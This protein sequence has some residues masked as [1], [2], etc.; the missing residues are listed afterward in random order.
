MTLLRSLNPLE[1][2]RSHWIVPF[3]SPLPFFWWLSAWEREL[4]WWV[5][6]SPLPSPLWSPAQRLLLFPLLPL[7]GECLMSPPSPFPYIQYQRLIHEAEEEKALKHV[8]RLPSPGVPPTWELDV[9]S[10]SFKLL[11]LLCHIHFHSTQGQGF[12]AAPERVNNSRP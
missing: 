10:V 4:S 5:S 7:T 12:V 8:C 6:L 9:L 11:L 2:K 3:F 1:F